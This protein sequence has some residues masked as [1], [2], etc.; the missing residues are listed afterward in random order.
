MRK[1]DW[2]FVS[3]GLSSKFRRNHPW[4]A[5]HFRQHSD[6]TT[7][8]RNSF[9]SSS[10]LVG[11]SVMQRRVDLGPQVNS[12]RT[13]SISCF[14]LCCNFSSR[15]YFFRT[16]ISF[17]F[18]YNGLLVPQIPRSPLFGWTGSSL[19]SSSKWKSKLMA[20]VVGADS[21]F[22]AIVSNVSS[23]GNKFVARVFQT[24]RS[25]SGCSSKMLAVSRTLEG[26]TIGDGAMDWLITGCWPL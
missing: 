12:P 16:N 18:D 22:A 25:G 8:W 2:R 6:C 21:R 26:R 10:F 15:F 11:I 4:R 5:T 23:C 17:C 19:W 7:V 24:S 13:V 14:A 1:N 20:P 3:S 9:L